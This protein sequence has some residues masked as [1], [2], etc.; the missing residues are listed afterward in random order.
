MNVLVTG[1]TG[2]IGGALCRHYTDK[3]EA[4]TVLT[5]DARRARDRLGDRVHAVET[6]RDL[7]AERA[8]EVVFNLAG[9]NLGS[10]RWTHA[11]KRRLISSR[12]AVTEHVVDYIAGAATRPAV[13]ISGS[14][15]GYYG[16]RGDTRLDEDA[17]PGNEFQS[18]LCEAWEAAALKAADHGTRVCLMRS[19]AVM[20]PG[21][22]P[23]AGLLPQFRYGL[24]GYAGDGRQWLSWIHIDDWIGLAEHLIRDPALEGPFNATSP[25]PETNREFAR[26]LG[27]VLS[28]PAWLRVPAWL[29]YLKQGEMARLFVTGQ[30]VLPKRALES[31]YGFRFPELTDALGDIL[32]QR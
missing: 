11:L 24:G 10:G 9:Q 22:G 15:V 2:F 14:A 19:G 16:A 3:G 8:P 5:R 32:S 12:V 21:G 23:L 30:R 4:V 6:L 18:R 25:G 20:G 27:R 13:L 28:R 1:G 26:K 31:G 7:S 29:V 17:A